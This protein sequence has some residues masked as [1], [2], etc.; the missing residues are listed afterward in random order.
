MLLLLSR[1]SRVR[2]CATPQMAAY[3]APP[4]LGFSRQ[5]HWS[6]LPFPSPMQESEKWKGSRSVVSD[7]SRLHGLQPTRLLRPWDFP[8]NSAG[9]RCHGLLQL[10]NIVIRY[11]YT[12]QTDHHD[13]FTY[14]VSPYK[15]LTY[16]FIVFPTLD[17]LYPWL[18]YFVTGSFYILISLTYFFPPATPLL[19][20]NH[21]FALCIYNC[22]FFVHFFCILDSTHKWNHILF[23]FLSLSVCFISLSIGNYQKQTNKKQPPTESEKIFANDTSDKG[24]ISNIQK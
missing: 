5:E 13:T 3:Q 10:Y 1:F 19:S 6:G 16:L 2:L 18:I 4:S 20:G 9:V 12:F 15:D 8:G 21:L 24:F 11:F 22:F 7:S 14:Y 17:I 23:V